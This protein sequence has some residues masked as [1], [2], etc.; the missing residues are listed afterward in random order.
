[1]LTKVR[2]KNF[3][4]FTKETIISFEASK[5]MI[6]ED[7]NVKDDILKGCCFYGSNASGK[8]NALNAITILLDLFFKNNAIDPT[9]I[10][11]FNKERVMYF[12]YTFKEASDTIVY[13]FEI[14]RK[15]KIT[16]ET[17]KINNKTMLTRLSNSAESFLTEN[18]DYDYQ[19][20]DENTLFLKKIYFNTG[21][22]EY[23]NLKNCFEFFKGNNSVFLSN[24][25]TILSIL[26]L[27]KNTFLLTSN[28]FLISK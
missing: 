13:Y 18:K 11:I 26:G 4:S 23:P 12:E 14:S 10:T 9:L 20:V 1:M 6:L 21:F 8:T 27:G 25:N 16:K 19:S 22:V 2:F 28:T 17:L 15:G 5:S 24:S 3:R 7:T